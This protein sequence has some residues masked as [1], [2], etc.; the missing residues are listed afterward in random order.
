MPCYLLMVKLSYALPG[1]VKGQ[2]AACLFPARLSRKSSS[3]QKPGKPGGVAST[4]VR[5]TPEEFFSIG[6]KFSAPEVVLQ[7]FK[8]AL[9][10]SLFQFHV[11]VVCQEGCIPKL[12]KFYA[13]QEP[14][15]L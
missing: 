2:V 8:N 6:D 4:D 3:L 11:D 9:S 13:I 10:F 14:H 7:E 15:G 12:C 5:A 1:D